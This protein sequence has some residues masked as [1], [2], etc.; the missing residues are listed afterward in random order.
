MRI[1]YNIKDEGET[2]MSSKE[3][4]MKKSNQLKNHNENQ[5][6]IEESHLLNENLYPQSK[7]EED[8]FNSNFGNDD[9]I[10][11]NKNIIK[12]TSK[13]NYEE[14]I[15]EN[16]ISEMKEKK[17]L[18]NLTENE[19][20]EKTDG[21]QEFEEILKNNEDDERILENNKDIHQKA[22]SKIFVYLKMK[23]K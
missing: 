4:D 20:I 1:I 3:D 7:N 14:K 22:L 23:N 11:Q 5:E 6:G 13:D 12:K 2:G 10:D 17:T 9:L 21:F 19:R 18:E 8:N 15:D 16:E